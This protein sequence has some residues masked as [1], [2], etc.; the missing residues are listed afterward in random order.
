MLY[1]HKYGMSCRFKL[2]YSNHVSIC[3]VHDTLHA[4]AILI[5]I[6]Y[7]VLVYDVQVNRPEIH[8]ETTLAINHIWFVLNVIPNRQRAVCCTS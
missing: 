7:C 2:C 6:K 1:L 3:S 5:T 8:V 4:I